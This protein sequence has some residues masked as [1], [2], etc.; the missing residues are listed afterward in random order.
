M[1]RDGGPR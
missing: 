1:V